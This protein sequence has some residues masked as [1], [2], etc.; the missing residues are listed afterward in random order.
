MQSRLDLLPLPVMANR[1]NK[2][3]RVALSNPTT[4][5]KSARL[6][7]STNSETLDTDTVH[8][9][10]YS[11]AADAELDDL[12]EGT[13]RGS[14]IDFLTPEEIQELEDDSDTNSPSPEEVLDV[15]NDEDLPA[16]VIPAPKPRIL[17][18]FGKSSSHGPSKVVPKPTKKL[19]NARKSVKSRQKKKVIIEESDEDEEPDREP[20]VQKNPS[21]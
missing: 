4:A 1:K 16:A 20:E 19:S 10:A 14:D 3:K 6:S 7:S 18:R 11:D 2:R 12:E 21:M 17:L 5:Q 8:E 13:A 9:E 15:S